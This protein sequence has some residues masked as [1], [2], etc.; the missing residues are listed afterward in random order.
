MTWAVATALVMVAARPP[1]Y[2]GEVVNYVYGPRV[3]I[4]PARAATAA[5]AA[6][7]AAVY[8]RLYAVSAAG[9]IPVLA[10]E[11]PRLDGTTVTVALRRN[12][13]LHDGRTLTPDLVVEALNRLD[14]DHA[15]GY[16]L[17]PVRRREGQPAIR[18]DAKRFA[19][20]FDLRYRDVD[21]PYLLA[22][23]HARLA[24]R[25]DAPAG[26]GGGEAAPPPLVGTGPFQWQSRNRQVPF[27][28]HRDGR[29]YAGRLVWRPYASRFG[30]GALAQRGQAPVFGG[31]ETPRTVNGPGS[32]LALQI[33]AGAGSDAARDQIRAHVHSSLRRPR[34]VRRYLGPKD[35]PATGFI[36]KPGPELSGPFQRTQQLALLA[37]RRL[38]FGHRVVERIQLDL[39][40]SGLRAQ[41]RWLDPASFERQSEE[42]FDLRLVEIRAG[43]IDDGSTRAALHRTLSVAAALGTLA[44]VDLDRLARF[45]AGNDTIRRRELAAIEQNVREAA[46]VI[47]VGRVVPAVALPADWPAPAFG[48][49][50]W[51]N[52]VPEATP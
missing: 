6:A 50:D 41:V 11:P 47:V 39:F 5:D 20:Q 48:E 12:V 15:G 35:E 30:A 52:L 33:G 17:L 22:S 8:E 19:V 32:W 2:G 7:H 14:G 46:Q 45:A 38:R 49:I 4:D 44:A 1:V 29:P 16:V 24:W 42:R 23:D 36:S 34:I 40:R 21:F 28:Q 27:K 13:I 18:S 10:R 25:I 31:P 43:V 26:G 3:T 37:T 51:A 9:L